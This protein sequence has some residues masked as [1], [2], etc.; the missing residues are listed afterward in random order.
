[1]SQSSIRCCKCAPT[2]FVSQTISPLVLW[3]MF[4]FSSSKWTVAPFSNFYGKIWVGFCLNTRKAF[5]LEVSFK[6]QKKTDFSKKGIT[7]FQKTRFFFWKISMFYVT[8][9]KRFACFRYFNFESNFVK[10]EILFQKTG[11]E[12]FSWKY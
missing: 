3:K 1:M 8:T 6:R 12:F 5:I 9:I 2:I 4:D 7:V 10:N 11:I